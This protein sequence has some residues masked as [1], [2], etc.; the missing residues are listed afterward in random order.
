MVYYFPVFGTLALSAA[1]ILERFVLKKRKI[2]VKLYQVASFLAIVIFM[3]PFIYFFWKLDS[4]ALAT[5]NVIIFLFVILFSMIANL[6]VF[7]SMKW[8]KIVNL[9]PAKFLEPL[10]VILLAIVFSFFTE[11]LYDRNLKIVIPA[12]ISGAALVF[13][14]LKK[15]HLEFNK[16][17]IA[18]ILGSF[19]FALELVTSKLILGFYS[20]VTFYFLR[21]S[22]IFLLSWII[23]KPKL[24]KIS[25]AVKL[26]IFLT[27]AIWVAY[28]I[29]VYYGYLKVGV[30]FTTLLLMLAPIL[31]Y[32]FAHFFLKEKMNWKNF[33]AAIVIVAS[34]AY[35]MFT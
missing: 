1:T 29:I 24:G 14:H 32:T 12:L 9:G 27:G 31:I 3:I 7:Y 13:S 6:F 18:A 22:S 4:G 8:E 5:K 11:G 20:P 19:F 10:F 25:K 28:R 30:I 17:F 23:F 2:D 16:Y 15:H 26:E 35:V 21:C 34:I 33:A